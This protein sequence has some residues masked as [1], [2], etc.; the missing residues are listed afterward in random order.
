MTKLNPDLKKSIE[1]ELFDE[2]GQLY[3]EDPSGASLSS[4]VRRYIERGLS[5]PTAYRIAKKAKLQSEI[6]G[7][8]T[9]Q[10]VD[11][12]PPTPAIHYQLVYQDRKLRVRLM[13]GAPWYLFSDVCRHV[14]SFLYETESL[15]DGVRLV[16]IPDSPLYR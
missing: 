1:T 7:Q 11:D 14:E 5:R 6:L 15:L 3:R 13:E 4:L 16:A 12:D 9:A 8:L 2:A 10:A